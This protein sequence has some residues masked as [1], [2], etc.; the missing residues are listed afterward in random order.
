MQAGFVAEKALGYAQSGAVDASTLI[1][2]LTFGSAGAAGIPSGTEL[3][4]IQPQTQAIRWRDDGTA[5]TAT[6]GYPLAVG[7]ELRYTGQNMAALRVISQVA[8]AIVNIL[9]YGTGAP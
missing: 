2:S 1:S 6:V 9:A 7:A 4:L 8:G 5:P 3:L